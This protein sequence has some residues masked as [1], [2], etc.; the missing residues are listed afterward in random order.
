VS[1]PPRLLDWHRVHQS[2]SSGGSQARHACCRLS[3]CFRFRFRAV[4]WMLDGCWMD[5]GGW[6]QPPGMTIPKFNIVPVRPITCTTHVCAAH[7][8][9][10]RREAA[11]L[12][13]LAAPNTWCCNDEINAQ[14]H[15]W[16]PPPTSL[17]H[18]L[19][20]AFRPACWILPSR[21]NILYPTSTPVPLSQKEPTAPLPTLPHGSA[22]HTG[23]P[24]RIITIFFHNR[25]FCF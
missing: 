1:A 3:T 5:V 23:R 13:H 10:Q 6:K 20:R 7:R 25:L 14:S 15:S 2:A 22:T 4:G 12:H 9:R 11:D 21:A 18:V 17:T 16:F 24:Q 19:R 8:R